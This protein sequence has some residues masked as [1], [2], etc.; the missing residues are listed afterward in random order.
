MPNVKLN[1][2]TLHYMTSQLC[3]KTTQTQRKVS[4][5]TDEFC[6]APNPLLIA[7]STQEY[8]TELPR[9]RTNQDLR[10]MIPP[11]ILKLNCQK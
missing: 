1:P 11:R 6:I 4:D 9:N 7:S 5:Q 10:T 8:K 3:T 2:T